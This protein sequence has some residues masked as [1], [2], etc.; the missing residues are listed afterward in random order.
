MTVEQLRLHWSVGLAP[1]KNNICTQ[2]LQK[3]S[4]LIRCD[5]LRFMLEGLAWQL[6]FTYWLSTKFTQIKL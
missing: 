2:N 5:W 3:K 4:Q 6:I 1:L